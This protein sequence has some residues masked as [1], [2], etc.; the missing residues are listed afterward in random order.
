MPINGC[1]EKK[2]EKLGIYFDDDG[3]PFRYNSKGLQE[4][5]EVP[6][7]T[8][9]LIT[10]VMVPEV[11][12]PLNDEEKE[13]LNYNFNITFDGADSFYSHYGVK[14]PTRLSHTQ[15]R[16][17]CSVDSYA[18]FMSNAWSAID[19]VSKSHNDEIIKIL[20]ITRMKWHL[21][22]TQKDHKG[23]DIYN[24]DGELELDILDKWHV[25]DQIT[26]KLKDSIDDLLGRYHD[27]NLMDSDM[28]EAMIE[29]GYT[30]RNGEPTP[31][32]RVTLPKIVFLNIR[33]QLLSRFMNLFKFKKN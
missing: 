27:L 26:N 24:K 5:C 30:L 29:V 15:L 1:D 19:Q 4:K 9:K 21:P 17:Y 33:N 12:I 6:F 28:M 18:N 13:S 20:T 22:T 14:T 23:R 10:S 25:W 3:N 11:E 32:E 31:K 7:A 16:H 8:L 2:L